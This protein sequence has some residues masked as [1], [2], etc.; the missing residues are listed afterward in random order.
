VPVP[1]P[2]PVLSMNGSPFVAALLSAVALSSVGRAQ[3]STAVPAGDRILQIEA[4]AVDRKGDPVTDLKREDLEVWINRHRIPIQTVAAAA[5]Q[6]PAPRLIILLLDDL[7]IDSQ[8]VPRA[9]DVARRFVNRMMPDDRMAISLL[10][11]SFMETTSDTSKLLQRV[12]SYNQAIGFLRVDD[13]G[14]FVLTNIAV[15]AREM[16]EAPDRRKAIVAIGS[17]YIFDTPIPPA[18][19]GREV[20]REWLDAVRALAAANVTFYVIDPGGVGSPRSG[21]G[22]AGFARDSGGHAFNDTNDLA[23][24]VEQIF[25]ERDNYYVISV[26]DPPVGRGAPIRDLEVRSL[27]RDITVRARRMITG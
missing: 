26:E 13:I 22:S 25:H 19:L 7:T 15:L 18:Q 1:V 23:W 20:R 17:G 21:S 11:G 8:M 10:T 14:A 5:A 24:A 16:I 6:E 4:V 9:R 27:R 12:D 3:N 2:V